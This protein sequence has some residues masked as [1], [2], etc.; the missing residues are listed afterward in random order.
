[1][2]D[3]S[4]VLFA[5]NGVVFL[6]DAMRN[7]RETVGDGCQIVVMARECREDVATYLTRQALKGTIAGFGFDPQG[8][9]RSH[10]GMDGAFYL[11][12]GQLLVRTQDGLRFEPGWLEKAGDILQ[13]HRDIGCLGF[14]SADR[15]KRRG[16]P[17]KP[18]SEAEICERIDWRCFATRRDVFLEHERQLL[19]ELIGWDC[20]FQ[21]RLKEIGLHLAYLPGQVTVVENVRDARAE[22][23]EALPEASVPP[24]GGPLGAM[25]RI[26]QLYHIA[27][28]V[29]MTCMSCGNT[30]LEVLAAQVEFCHAHEVPV[31]FSYTMRCSECREL[32]YE[33]DLQFQCPREPLR[34]T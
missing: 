13:G 23:V 4:I 5:N 9:G 20:P 24:H 6:R 10:C 8:I 11:T 29:A 22:E 7:L 34:P 30:E 12:D 14:L 15:A 25:E 31:G 2:T 26:Q 27:D 16:R 17:P 32:H 3:V 28:D 21:K 18:R 33:E 1:M 19:N